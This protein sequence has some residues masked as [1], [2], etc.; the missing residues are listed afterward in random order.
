MNV[1]LFTYNYNVF[2]FIQIILF[3]INML[4]FYILPRL[5]LAIDYK[6]VFYNLFVSGADIIT[7][8]QL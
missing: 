5:V 1:F 2:V 8:I 4:Y 6:I 3:K 7:V